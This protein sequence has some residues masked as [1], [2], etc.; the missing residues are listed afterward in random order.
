[1]LNIIEGTDSTPDGPRFSTS[2]LDVLLGCLTL[3]VLVLG[4]RGV[5]GSRR[6]AIRYALSRA[7]TLLR[8]IPQLG[9]LAVGAAF[10][11]IAGYVL[12]GRDVS[13]LAAAYGWPAL[14]AFVLAAMVASAASLIADAWQLIRL[15]RAAPDQISGLATSGGPSS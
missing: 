1:V 7:R 9:V 13:W 6:R 12:G 4:V 14:V 8:L 11:D 5:L 15:R 10:P 3:A 2:T